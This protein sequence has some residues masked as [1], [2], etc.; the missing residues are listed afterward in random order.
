M[1]NILEKINKA[2]LKFLTPLSEEEMY[3]TIV[4]E[5]TKLIDAEYGS[6]FLE[7][8]GALQRVYASSPLFY[9]VK[10]NKDGY[11]YKTYQ[12][13]KPIV[14]TAK[15]L[16][17]I[18]PEIA[19]LHLNSVIL[20]PLSYKEET[21]GVLTIY[22]VK[23]AHF[24]NKELQILRLFGSM[25]SLAIRKTELYQETK[26]ALEVRDRFISLASHE[27][28]TPL[29][30]ING[31]IQ[32]L[33]S[34]VKDKDTLD[35]KWIKELYAESIRLTNLVKELLEINRVKTGQLHFTFQESHLEK[36]LL[37]AIERLKHLYPDR[38]ILYTSTRKTEKDSVIGDPDK[39]L[40]VFSAILSN[41]IKFSP[42]SSPVKLQLSFKR[43]HFIISIE[44]EGK[45]IQKKE[46]QQIFEG[47]YKGIDNMQEG[48][49]VGLLL[50]RHIIE[51]HQGSI[52]I[53][54]SEKE[55]TKVLIRLRESEL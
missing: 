50:S 27:L 34:R 6:I 41:A 11:V 31:Y 30:S 40:Q 3:K 25:A 10:I 54:K 45:G 26:H 44:D 46:I 1:E 17:R 21:L 23:D 4:E 55:G 51:S 2:A 42:S 19:S 15:N 8:N 47:F 22:S 53:E 12:S 24:T 37:T 29:T 38:T 5:G 43:P 32:L 18:F 28:R 49:G 16:E 35:A 9:G 33:L 20:M 7:R 36:I 48:F 52:N 14:G 39:L 13:K